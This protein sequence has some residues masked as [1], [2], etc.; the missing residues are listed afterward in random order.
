MNALDEARMII[1]MSD[2]LRRLHFIE[3]EGSRIACYAIAGIDKF[4]GAK[5][6]H[7]ALVAERARRRLF[8]TKQD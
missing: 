6:D 7:A 1:S 5:L 8:P 3:I 2:A 4:D